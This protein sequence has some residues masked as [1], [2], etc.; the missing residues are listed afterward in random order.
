MRKIR[1]KEL[2]LVAPSLPEL[3]DRIAQHLHTKTTRYDFASNGTV[4]P[5]GG[6]TIPNVR[7]RLDGTK[8]RLEQVG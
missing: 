4:A 2:P 5:L 6:A 3:H 1:D 7:W 8:Y